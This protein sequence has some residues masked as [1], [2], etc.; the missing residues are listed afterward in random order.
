M[1]AS[2]DTFMTLISNGLPTRAVN[3]VRFEK[4]NPVS[5]LIKDN[6]VNIQFLNADVGQS[7][8]PSKLM[9]AVNICYDDEATAVQVAREVADILWDGA[10]PKLDY[11]DPD[12]PQ[13]TGYTLF[14]DSQVIKF[15]PINDG[16]Q[17]RLY[18]LLTIFHRTL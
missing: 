9:A 4:D 5:S 6:A 2:R 18:C 1:I 13:P 16:T 15:R 14:W 3:N 12:N 17:F 7:Y 11:T 10:C 8:T